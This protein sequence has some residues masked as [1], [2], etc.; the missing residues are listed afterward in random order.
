MFVTFI[1]H[2]Y[3][4]WSL[5]LLGSVSQQAKLNHTD[6]LYNKATN[7]PSKYKHWHNNKILIFWWQKTIRYL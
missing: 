6:Q 1:D 2:M 4:D 3:L 7:N 5:P